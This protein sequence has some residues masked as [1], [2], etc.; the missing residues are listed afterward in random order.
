[1]SESKYD[2][3]YYKVSYLKVHTDLLR[4]EPCALMLLW[5]TDWTEEKRSLKVVEKMTQQFSGEGNIS[6]VHGPLHN[7]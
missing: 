6:T 4:T 2:E 7:S 3:K 5:G 1:M